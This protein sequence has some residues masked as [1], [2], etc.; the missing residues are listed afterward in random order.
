MKNNTKRNP[1]VALCE[2]ASQNNWCWK[3]TCT[4]CG[5]SAFK[6][7]FSKLVRGEHPDD[8]SFWLNGKEN[9]SALKE[10]EKYDDFRKRNIDSDIQLRLAKIVAKAKICDIQKISRF[11]DWLGYIGLVVHYC[12]NDEASK[13]LSESLILQFMELLKD[14]K[15]ITENLNK[16]QILF[17]S[18]LEELEDSIR[19]VINH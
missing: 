12:Y 6:V 14:D 1:F 18:D 13:I 15:Y 7:A 5:H 9:H 3:I 8:D 11:P 4:T 19:Y 17:I 16:K 2:Y 10:I